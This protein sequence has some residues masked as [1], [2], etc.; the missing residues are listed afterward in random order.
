MNK[1]ATEKLLCELY[2]RF[3]HAYF[4]LS[5][6]WLANVGS[7]DIIDHGLRFTITAFAD[8]FQINGTRG[9]QT[10]SYVREQAIL[11]LA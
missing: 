11:F 5:P 3:P 7:L 6:P 8:H 2:R 9:R 1:V 4:I 10:F